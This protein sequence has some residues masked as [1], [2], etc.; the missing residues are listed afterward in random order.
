MQ[1]TRT[2]VSLYAGAGG[3]DLGFAS[4]GFVPVWTNEANHDAARTYESL[5]SDILPEEHE[6]VIG[7]IDEAELPERG[8]ADLL[9]GGPPCQGFSRAGKQDPDDPRSTHVRRF[10]QAVDQIRPLAFIMENVSS[11]ANHPRWSPLRAWINQQVSESGYDTQWL[12]LDAADFGV[13]QR[14]QRMFLVGGRGLGEL[15]FDDLNRPPASVAGA[16]SALPPFGSPEN[17]QAVNARIVFARNP[18]LRKSPYAGMLFNGA[19]RP[20]RLHDVATTIP[21]SI[22]GNIAPIVDQRTL[23]DGAHPWIE[24]YH[25]HLIGG[26]RPFVGEA[27]DRLR[28]ITAEEA[29]ALQAFPM[30]TE[31]KGSLASRL[32]QIGNAVPPPLAA[33]VATALKRALPRASRQVA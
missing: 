2:F 29:A 9:I 24:E 21:A 27:P 8:S 1:Q 11:L 20:L 10:F 19:G 5:L 26:G 18:V 15:R 31:F 4:E 7:P 25:A 6:L 28:R 13:P 3:L 22:A 17:S 12:Q 14:R 30:G 32:T 33:A 23:C 16:L